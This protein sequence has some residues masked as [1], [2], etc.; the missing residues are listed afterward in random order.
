MEPP[1]SFQWSTRLRRRPRRRRRICESSSSFSSERTPRTTREARDFDRR[2]SVSAS[3]SSTESCSEA[4]LCS[5]DE[6]EACSEET[7]ETGGERGNE[8]SNAKAHRRRTEQPDV[9]ARRRK[10]Y[11]LPCSRERE[12]KERGRDPR[13]E[14]SYSKRLAHK[15]TKSVSSTLSPHSLSAFSSLSAA[16]LFPFSNDERSRTR[17][18]RTHEEPLSAKKESLSLSHSACVPLADS[19][20]LHASPPGSSDTSSRLS[21]G[22]GGRRDRRAVRMGD[23]GERGG[24]EKRRRRTD[25]SSTLCGGRLEGEERRE[26]M[27]R[28]KSK[29]QQRK[30][31]EDA[32]IISRRDIRTALLSQ[33]T[34]EEAT[35]HSSFSSS[36][37]DRR[38]TKLPSLPTLPFVSLDVHRRTSSPPPS[39]SP[40]R[41]SSFCHGGQQSRQ[42]FDASPL[43]SSSLRLAS[44]HAVRKKQEQGSRERTKATHAAAKLNRSSQR[45]S[46]FP[47]SSFPSSPLS[48][49][50]PVLPRRTTDISEAVFRGTKGAIGMHQSSLVAAERRF[51][52]FHDTSCSPPS[53]STVEA[54]PLPSFS[55]LG[56]FESHVY[57]HPTT[58]A[59]ETRHAE[60]TNAAP[61]SSAACVFAVSSSPSI[62]AF[63]SVSCDPSE[64]EP[65]SPSLS[66]SL[67]N[68]RHCQPASPA[69]SPRHRRRVYVHLVDVAGGREKES[70]SATEKRG[71]SG[72]HPQ[73][74]AKHRE[75]KDGG[76]RKETG[77]EMPRKEEHKFLK[78]WRVCSAFQGFSGKEERKKERQQAANGMEGERVEEVNGKE[79][80]E[81][82]TAKTG[83]EGGE[84]ESFIERV[85]DWL[86]TDRQHATVF[87]LDGREG[88]ERQGG[89]QR[90]VTEESRSS[91]C[92]SSSPAASSHSGLEV[93]RPP[94]LLGRR[95]NWTQSPHSE[96]SRKGESETGTPQVA[97]A[98][99]AEKL[100]T[101]L[102]QMDTDGDGEPVSFLLG[103]SVFFVSD[104]T[105][106]DLLSSSPPA[107]GPSSSP[108]CCF[109]CFAQFLSSET[110]SAPL[111]SS[112]CTP[113]DVV[114][115]CLRTVSVSSVGEVKRVLSRAKANL[116]ELR[117]SGVSSGRP[118]EENGKGETWAKP[119]RG[120]KHAEGTEA[121]SL[122]AVRVQVLSASA[123]AGTSPTLSLLH[124][125]SPVE[126]EDLES[127]QMTLSSEHFPCSVE[128]SK[129]LVALLLEFLQL[130]LSSPQSITSSFYLHSPQCTHA[131]SSSAGSRPGSARSSAA[132]APLDVR[133]SR[134]PPV[135]LL[136]NLVS[137]H[138]KTF[139]LAVLPSLT[140]CPYTAVV[141]LDAL[142]R[143]S[144]HGPRCEPLQFS[145]SFLD[146]LGSREDPWRE[147]KESA[148]PAK[149]AGEE[150]HRRCELLERLSRALGWLHAGSTG[151]SAE[152]RK[153]KRRE[154][155]SPE[156]TAPE[157]EGLCQAPSSD[158]AS[159]PAEETGRREAAE[160]DRETTYERREKARE[161]SG[162]EE[163]ERDE[164]EGEENEREEYKRKESASGEQGRHQREREPTHRGDTERREDEENQHVATVNERQVS[165]VEARGR[166][167]THCLSRS[168]S[169]S[170]PARGSTNSCFTDDKELLDDRRNGTLAS[171]FFSETTHT[172]P[173]SW[174]NPLSAHSRASS[175]LRGRPATSF[176]SSSASAS[177]NAVAVSEEGDALSLLLPTAVLRP[178]S[179]KSDLFLSRSRDEGERTNK[180]QETS[181]AAF[182][183]S[184]S[185][186]S[187]SSSA[188]SRSLLR[189][190]WEARRWSSRLRVGDDEQAIKSGR[191]S[192]ALKATSFPGV[193]CRPPARL[194]SQTGVSSARQQ[195][196]LLARSG[197]AKRTAGHASS[198]SPPSSAFFSF[199][200]RR[201][202]RTG[203]GAFEQPEPRR[204]RDKSRGGEKERE[205]RRVQDYSV[206]SNREKNEA[207]KSAERGQV[208]VLL[209]TPSSERTRELVKR[210]SFPRGSE[211]TRPTFAAAKAEEGMWG[212]DSEGEKERSQ[213]KAKPCKGRREDSGH[214]ATEPDRDRRQN[215]RN[216]AVVRPQ[217]SFAE[218]IRT[219]K[220]DPSAPGAREK[221]SRSVCMRGR[222]SASSCRLQEQGALPSNAAAPSP[223][224][225]PSSS[226]SPRGSFAPV[227]N[228]AFPPGVRTSHEQRPARQASGGECELRGE[229]RAEGQRVEEQPSNKSHD[230]PLTLSGTRGQT[231]AHAAPVLSELCHPKSILGTPEE[232]AWLSPSE[233][234]AQQAA[235][236][237]AVEEPA[238][239]ETQ[240]DSE[241]RGG[242]EPGDRAEGERASA[243][244]R[245]REDRRRR[246]TRREEDADRRQQE[247]E[248]RGSGER[249][250]ERTKRRGEESPCGARKDGPRSQQRRGDGKQEKDDRERETLRL[251]REKDLQ[252]EVIRLR[253]LLRRTLA[254]RTPREISGENFHLMHNAAV[255]DEDSLRVGRRRRTQSISFCHAVPSPLCFSSLPVSFLFLVSQ[256][257]HSLSLDPRASQTCLHCSRVEL[258]P[259]EELSASLSSFVSPFSSVSLFSTHSLDESS[260]RSGP[261]SPRC[262]LLA[263]LLYLASSD[264]AH[265]RGFAAYPHKNSDNHRWL[266]FSLSLSPIFTRVFSSPPVVSVCLSLCIAFRLS[267][268]H[269][270]V[271]EQ[272]SSVSSPPSRE[273]S[274]DRA[275]L[276]CAEV[277]DE[278]RSTVLGVSESF[279]VFTCEDDENCLSNWCA[280]ERSSVCVVHPSCVSLSSALCLR[281]W[282]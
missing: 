63:L 96:G 268:L 71:D 251:V 157:G 181:E 185:S 173:A 16:S 46:A 51:N 65:R 275:A 118:N 219:E 221:E 110:S 127:P 17:R 152:S 137:I 121:P 43:A 226:P 76:D 44:P 133:C 97:D 172:V 74:G 148:H 168:S 92:S 241:G 146:S 33:A 4:P 22:P 112:A 199:S 215:S 235:S 161:R 260:S 206:R 202:L 176:S 86:V 256:R 234:F 186:S 171:R 200:G 73:R 155:P 271:V 180:V 18:T 224:S 28:K 254:W 42:R 68:F 264:S 126:G 188:G 184:S 31:Q 160:Q 40:F 245:A 7:R 262:F 98:G 61:P 212:E 158:E 174:M 88:T 10:L 182:P 227:K 131:S 130:P 45:P 26:N 47:P 194:A 154:T 205:G 39:C 95:G 77:P 259:A 100:L 183:S 178:S 142:Q 105:T 229:R 238:E 204:V 59:P 36:I 240:V 75:E 170:T 276:F 164:N 138:S 151:R 81:G 248:Q 106:V 253:S 21:R 119:R 84:K 216:V 11:F 242:P 139:A 135:Q 38:P 80:D 270:C 191:L 150:T 111:A 102:L 128:G 52:A 228:A 123:S 209:S 153:K 247:W 108:P 136:Q 8:N 78:S 189:T 79:G 166:V 208:R 72:E 29:K 50:L 5:T 141:L 167:S 116:E 214:E 70:Q 122:L 243:A 35:R 19:S 252:L 273:P 210:I 53:S 277:R 246:R 6:S 129:R 163:N 190:R 198:S 60:A 282:L 82:E 117:L 15:K 143:G 207:G 104:D 69:F 258:E 269:A 48:P 30:Q 85:A 249:D 56:F 94:S 232:D 12:R 93:S 87:L 67:L 66:A 13:E 169:L 55:R 101:R 114:S 124:L 103:L 9:P 57:I 115:R 230:A 217:L 162:G 2:S 213:R 244:A 3:S 267:F 250:A 90:Q 265:L 159:K 64:D 125:I 149:T 1:S 257:S 222:V 263:S 195:A 27:R 24:E 225:S 145:P 281:H 25:A 192:T 279:F 134:P 266:P 23:V 132:A 193:S 274:R 201:P 140:R 187:A 175:Q 89:E 58:C 41:P 14:H 20:S 32:H 220:G 54:F 239:T 99:L 113:D 223:R 272:G 156:V 280:E 237:G 165:S 236:L 218:K 278:G 34:N 37:Y 196:T 255:G 203:A 62:F 147:R 261:A 197:G 49:H 107:T 144:L 233:R 179:P 91:S 177:F 83:G 211:R 109:A 231:A 120:R